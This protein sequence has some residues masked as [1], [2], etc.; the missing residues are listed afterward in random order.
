VRFLQ[1]QV[2]FRPHDRIAVA[3]ELAPAPGSLLV[4]SLKSTNA[5]VEI[6][7]R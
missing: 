1:E 4:A 7:S 3:D 6:P 5:V 2:I